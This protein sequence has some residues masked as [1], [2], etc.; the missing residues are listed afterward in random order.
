MHACPTTCIS[1]M[2]PSWSRVQDI[3]IRVCVYRLYQIYH[4][5]NIYCF[6]YTYICSI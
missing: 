1:M 4:M 5:V 6:R 3:C 2:K